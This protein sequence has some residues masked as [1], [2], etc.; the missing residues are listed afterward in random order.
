MLSEGFEEV[1]HLKGGILKYLEVI[2]PEQSKWNGECYVFDRRV[3]VGHGLTTGR[4]SMCFT[5]GYPLHVDDTHHPL[6]EEGV[7]CKHCHAH[8]SNDDK[9][10]YRMRQS[11]C[12]EE[13]K[14]QED[15][16]SFSSE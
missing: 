7:S 4:F 1:Y 3:A 6:Y 16:A 12:G 14:A 2:P 5:C 15:C 9:I 8:T 11:Q 10:R 13:E